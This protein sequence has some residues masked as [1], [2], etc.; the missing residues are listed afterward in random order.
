M[1]LSAPVDEIAWIK[2]S[3]IMSQIIRSILPTVMAPLTV[4]KRTQSLSPVIASKAFAPRATCAARPPLAARP[5]MKE[6]IELRLPFNHSSRA[7]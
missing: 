5:E 1:S 6:L 3:S 2:P 4:R 7:A